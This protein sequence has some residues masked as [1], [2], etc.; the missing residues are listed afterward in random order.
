MPY[1]ETLEGRIR[2]ILPGHEKY[3]SKKMFGGI[4]FLVSG[5]MF[6]GVYRDHL[7]LRLPETEAREALSLPGARPFDITGKPMKGWVMIREQDIGDDDAVPRL[8]GKALPHAVAMPPKKKKE[9]D[10]PSNT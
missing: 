3:E 4:C 7:I 2:K 8:T 5:N 9:C 6:C 10:E 1:S